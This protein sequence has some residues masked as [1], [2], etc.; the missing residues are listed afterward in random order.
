MRKYMS[1]GCC[2]WNFFVFGLLVHEKKTF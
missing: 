1:K 2:I